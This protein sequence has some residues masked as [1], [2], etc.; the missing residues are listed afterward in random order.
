MRLMQHGVPGRRIGDR[1]ARGFEVSLDGILRRGVTSFHSL[2]QLFRLA[3]ISLS[4]GFL[5]T[6][7]PGV[8]RGGCG[9]RELDGLYDTGDC[10]S[11][12][13]GLECRLGPAV[14]RARPWGGFRDAPGR[15]RRRRSLK[16]RKRL[17]VTSYTGDRF[18]EGSMRRHRDYLVSALVFSVSLMS[19]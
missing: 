1:D 18:R 7:S 13:R 3:F 16:P 6:F 5:L 8:V 9:V 12:W 19:K 15:I 4:I 14:R 2:S 11:V 10:C 17:K